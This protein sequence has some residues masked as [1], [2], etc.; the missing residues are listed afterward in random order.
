MET[1][2]A[3]ETYLTCYKKLETENAE[4][5]MKRKLQKMS[6]SLDS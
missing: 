5:Q 2:D 1:N 6:L 4:I 3:A